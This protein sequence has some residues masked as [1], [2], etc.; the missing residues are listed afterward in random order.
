MDTGGRFPSAD[1][2]I[3]RYLDHRLNALRFLPCLLSDSFW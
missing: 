2:F 1:K 3:F